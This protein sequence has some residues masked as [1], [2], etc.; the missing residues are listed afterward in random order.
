M[1]TLDW[2][3]ITKNKNLVRSSD[4]RPCG[5][6]I[7]EYKDNIFIIRGE[8]I[9]SCEYM[10]PKTKIDHYDGEELFLDLPYDKLVDFHY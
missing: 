7:A 4:Q 6:I 9:K 8:T 5:N 2:D 3:E 10:I 1:L